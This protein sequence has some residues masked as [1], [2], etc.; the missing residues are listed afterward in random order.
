MASIRMGALATEIAGSIGGTTFRR[1]AS[2]IVAFNKQKGRS[3]SLNAQN[4]ALT[5]IQ[6]Y[7]QDWSK[8]T[9]INR[10][11]WDAVA[12]KFERTD[13]FGNRVPY[14]G[15]QLFVSI[16]NGIA[17]TDIV[18]PNPNDISSVVGIPDIGEVITGITSEFSVEVYNPEPDSY[19]CIQVQVLK[20][21]SSKPLY[22]RYKTIRKKIMTTT[23][24]YDFSSDVKYEPWFQ[25]PGSW[26]AIWVYFVN[27]TGWRGP[28]SVK[29]SLVIFF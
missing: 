28:S 15:R 20:N 3:K 2:G 29:K 19:I 24:Y 22:K 18:L 21:E 13:R 26:I 10:D 9:Q 14:T 12:P 5:R 8:L 16:K 27:K 23:R 11:A 25:F 4:N 6:S 7:I 1:G 17:G